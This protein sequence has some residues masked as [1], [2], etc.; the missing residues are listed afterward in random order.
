MVTEQTRYRV[1]GAVFLVALAVIIVPMLFDG[2]GIE[3]LDLPAL[4][5]QNMSLPSIE[6]PPDMSNVITQTTKIRAEIDD[7]GYRRDSGTRVGEPVLLPNDD[8]TVDASTVA[9]WA[10]Q[11]ASFSDR[12][13]AVALRD[14]LLEDGY[15]ALMSSHREF[16]EV[17]F[18][19]AV[20]PFINEADVGRIRDELAERY[21]M[22]AIVVR[23]SH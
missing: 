14:K 8:S 21:G 6:S 19:V 15:Q 7:D 12:G 22:E 23:F 18:R 16:A 2:D 4:T 17:R 9:A 5:P 13:N 1:T 10:V 20:G 11:I 3:P